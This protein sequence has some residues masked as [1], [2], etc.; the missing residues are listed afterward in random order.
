M[1]TQKLFRKYS[2]NK[3]LSIK[4]YKVSP[5]KI[6]S[7]LYESYLSRET[8]TFYWKKKIYTMDPGDN[9]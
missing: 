6:L 5:G 4:G 9:S 7:S 2:K 1:H 8:L 3:R